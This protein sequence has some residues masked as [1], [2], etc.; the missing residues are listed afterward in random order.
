MT[1]DNTYFL[2]RSN[3]K[4]EGTPVD[5]VFLGS[6]T[7]GNETR[8]ETNTAN[9][10][11]RN[12]STGNDANPGTEAQPVETQAAAE[13]L[14]VGN[15]T[16]VE[17]QT[18]DPITENINVQTQ[19]TTGIVGQLADGITVNAT[20]TNF[21]LNG[22]ITSAT[23]L[24]TLFNCSASLSTASTF[25]TASAGLSL[26]KCKFINSDVG[27]LTLSGTANLSLVNTVC[28][29]P[30]TIDYTGTTSNGVT[31]N[32]ST[33]VGNISLT[34]VSDAGRYQFRDFI[35]EGN[36][37]SDSSSALILLESGNIRGVPTN[38]S[39]GNLTQVNPLFVDPSTSDY[40]LQRESG[41]SDSPGTQD[42]ALIGAAQFSTVGATS[43][44]AELGAH[45]FD[46]S[47]IVE[48]FTN[49]AFIKKP[50]SRDAIKITDEYVSNVQLSLLGEPDV[51]NQR[52]RATEKVEMQFDAFSYVN[53]ATGSTGQYIEFIES[54]Q[55]T[56]VQISWNPGDQ[57]DLPTV[58][59]N[60]DQG[61]N[62]AAITINAATVLPGTIIKLDG[63][64]YFVQYTIPAAQP[65]T[66]L[67]L[68]Q[69]LESSLTDGQALNL[70]FP[71]GSGRITGEF[72]YVPQR[73]KR[74]SLPSS[75]DDNIQAGVRLVF[76]RKKPSVS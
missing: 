26:Q 2:L 70:V 41:Y 9:I 45:T 52:Q 76:I 57:I 16:T 43:V 65:T 1:I 72:E 49:A 54:L 31:L 3:P 34:S 30:I 56:Q 69:P 15:F 23:N 73:Q 37:T 4:R 62:I 32:K 53:T 63:Q 17:V 55:N 6:R 12:A 35:I 5:L 10:I 20:L 71:F 21:Q 19:P 22:A 51:F 47:A 50:I 36:I 66:Q 7:D 40:R 67:V 28:Q 46:D 75:L 13:A 68:N 58:T 25:I 44:P 60:G 74:Y 48:A 27:G 29:A 59:V 42:S 8:L 39:I 33:I 18:A 38:F 61:P 14:V 11:Y 24:I 64:T